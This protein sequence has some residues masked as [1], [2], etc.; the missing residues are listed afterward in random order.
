MTT[1]TFDKSLELIAVGSPISGTAS[2]TGVALNPRFLPTCDWVIC[3]TSVA[4]SGSYVFTL[5]VSDVVGGSYTTMATATWPS[6][7][8]SGRMKVPIQGQ[9]AAMVDADAKFMN[10]TYTLGGSSPSLV[11]ESF[12]A[13]ASN[14]AGTAS[15]PGDILTV[16]G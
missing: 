5:G 12:L 3:A 10:V 16:T 1:S 14:N 15:R 9:H 11:L 2:S 8:A 4:P 7:V 6:G 13:L